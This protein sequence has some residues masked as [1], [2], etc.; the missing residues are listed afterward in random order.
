MQIV[1]AEPEV[2]DAVLTPYES[3][4]FVSVEAVVDRAGSLD[5]AAKSSGAGDAATEE[6]GEIAANLPVTT[7]L[8]IFTIQTNAAPAVQAQG[9][10]DARTARVGGRTVKF[11]GKKILFGE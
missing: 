6:I 1:F 8:T 10:G 7:F 5:A 3:Q 11:D 4:Y 9:A 2:I